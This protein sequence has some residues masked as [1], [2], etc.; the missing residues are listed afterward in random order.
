MK[1]MRVRTLALALALCCSAGVLAQAAT[2]P[3]V[4]TARKRAKQ[5]RKA[6]NKRIK[7]QRVQAAKVK[8]AKVH[9]A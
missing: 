4:K 3:A 1:N 9:K 8:R 7:S 5:N 2:N 6:I